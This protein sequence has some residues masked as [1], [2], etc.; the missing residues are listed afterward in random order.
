MKPWLAITAVVLLLF[1]WALSGCSPP[2]GMRRITAWG[3]W[4]V[5]FGAP[6]GIGYWHSEHG[7]GVKSEESENPSDALKVLP[8]SKSNTSRLDCPPVYA[9]QMGQTIRF[10]CAEWYGQW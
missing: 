10:S 3:L 4:A 5:P 2:V 9:S 8:G 6:V 7:V 1:A